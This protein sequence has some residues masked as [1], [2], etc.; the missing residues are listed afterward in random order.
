MKRRALAALLATPVLA[1]EAATRIL[2]GVAPGGTADLSARLLAQG[3]GA[4]LNRTV[5]VENRPG[6]ATQIATRAVAEAPPDGTNL[7]VAGAPFAINPALF[8]NLPYDT[9]R[10]FA[11][12]M[13]LVQGGLLLLL[14]AASPLRDLGTFLTAARLRGINIGSAGNG[15][16]SHMALELLALRAG[17]RMNHVP[18]RGSAPAIADLVGGQIEAMFDNAN[19][20]LP[21]VREGRLRALAFSGA[22]RNPAIPDAPAL[23]EVLPGFLAVNWFGVF[24]RAA[25]PDALLD[26]LATDAAAIFATPEMRERFARDGDEAAPLPRAA[27]ADFVR[28]E[29][30]VWA[31]VVRERRIS[32]G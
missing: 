6:A 29:M 25:T 3:L 22:S 2:V 23:A 26:R 1:Q 9:A 13:R 24:A 5:L 15:S 31:E 11:P 10:D 28:S 12:L 20:A 4:R 21:L 19:T 27:F 17:A 8:A 18:Y 32:P 30:R 14:P 16:M 7:L